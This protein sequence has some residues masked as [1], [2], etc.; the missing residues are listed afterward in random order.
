[1]RPVLFL[2][3]EWTSSWFY[4]LPENTLWTQQLCFPA[5]YVPC[6]V[7][8]ITSF[9]HCV[10]RKS[11]KAAR[12]QEI[13]CENLC[14]NYFAFLASV[15]A[16]SKHLWDSWIPA[17][18]T[19]LT[20]G[21]FDKTETFQFLWKSRSTIANR[22]NMQ[23]QWERV[24]PRKVSFSPCVVNYST[25]VQTHETR[26]TQLYRQNAGVPFSCLTFNEYLSSQHQ[27]NLNKRQRTTL[28]R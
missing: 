2:D 26:F 25:F 20:P 8:K 23:G 27:R 15:T 10:L 24:A 3:E 17:D 1:M 19:K 18:S 12:F 21:R 14:F 16:N 11:G 28:L 9:L 4:L 7:V 13:L 22:Q 6:I 5:Q